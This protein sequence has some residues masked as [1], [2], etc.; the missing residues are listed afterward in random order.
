MNKLW[1]RRIKPKKTGYFWKQKNQDDIDDYEPELIYY[2]KT[3]DKFW[4]VK[5]NWVQKEN[6]DLEFWNGPLEPPNFILQGEEL[7][8]ISKCRS[9]YDL[10]LGKLMNSI[11]SFMI[12]NPERSHDIT[13]QLLPKS[14]SGGPLINDKAIKELS[15]AIICSGPSPVSSG[16]VDGV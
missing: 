4:S 16:V 13:I 3:T 7:C 2:D 14:V 12:N 9:D 8:E 15:N 10:E 5:D 11:Y 6:S 1:F